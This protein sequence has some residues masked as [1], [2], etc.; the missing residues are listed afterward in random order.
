MRRVNILSPKEGFGCLGT[1]SDDEEILGNEQVY[2]FSQGS[3][4]LSRDFNKLGAFF[5]AAFLHP[6]ATPAQVLPAR[7]VSKIQCRSS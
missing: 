3:K 4:L 7:L 2:L 5:A 6:Q 1:R